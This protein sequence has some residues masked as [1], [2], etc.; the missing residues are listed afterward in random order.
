MTKEQTLVSHLIELRSCLIRSVSATLLVFVLLAAFSNQIY[1]LIASPLIEQ[2]PANSSM[3]ATEVAAPF[4]A[5][6]KLTLFV[7]LFL[8]MPY[9]LYEVWRFI[10]PGLYEQEKSLAIPL[11]ISSIVLFYLGIA[12]SFFVVFPLLFAFLTAAAPEGVTV[13]TDISHYLNFI[14]KLFFGFGLA[15]EVPILT[16]ILLRT[17]ITNAESLRQKR[18]Y[19]IITAFVVGMLLTPPDIISQTLLAIPVWLL[20]ELG[21]WMGENFFT[22]NEKAELNTNQQD[23]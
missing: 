2:L 20:F 18:P 11:L 16:I 12:F 10:A 4:L 8:V 13:M 14:L 22:I 21:L 15:F 3:I 1:Q 5:P 19:I 9:I 7:A 6:F 17:G 23:E